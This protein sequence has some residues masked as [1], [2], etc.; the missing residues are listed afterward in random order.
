MFTTNKQRGVALVEFALVVPFL[1]T[2]MLVTIE[3]SRAFYQ[4]NTL[5]KAVRDAARYLS[6]QMPGTGVE[7]ATNLIVYGTTTPGTQPLAPG[8]SATHV[9][10]PVWSVIGAAPT[11]NVVTVRIQGYQFVPL[12]GTVFWVDLG[13]I[14]FPIISATMPS[15]LI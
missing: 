10:E 13:M 15:P 12:W 1:L 2:L 3:F 5:T 6:V 14:P 4:Y 11:V 8:L 9:D 7:E